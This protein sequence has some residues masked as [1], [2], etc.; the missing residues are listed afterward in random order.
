[1]S[2]IKHKYI[3]IF[4]EKDGIG[5]IKMNR[6]KALNALSKELLTELEQVVEYVE[7]TRSRK[8]KLDKRK[9][10]FSP[11]SLGAFSRKLKSFSKKA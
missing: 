10:G 2:I 7:K 3:S 9:E 1:L 11:K 4:E 6:P 8:E 5:F